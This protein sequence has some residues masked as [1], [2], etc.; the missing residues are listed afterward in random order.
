MP[1]SL[2]VNLLHLVM[3]FPPRSHLGNTTNHLNGFPY[4]Y[5]HNVAHGQDYQSPGADSGEY[6]GCTTTL[7][8]SLA[9]LMKGATP[10]PGLAAGLDPPDRVAAALGQVE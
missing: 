3:A 4:N 10:N 6:L 5:N 1:A 9:G 7:G 2:S 8:Y